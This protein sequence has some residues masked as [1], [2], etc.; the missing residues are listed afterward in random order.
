MYIFARPLEVIDRLLKFLHNITSD[1]CA[2]RDINIYKDRVLKMLK[3]IGKES[4]EVYEW[5]IPKV[6]YA[7]GDRWLN[8]C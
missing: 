4:V 7:V 8:D 3:F 6:D 5:S 1:G 2:R